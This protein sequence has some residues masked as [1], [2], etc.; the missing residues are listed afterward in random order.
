M[1]DVFAPVADVRIKRRLPNTE[2]PGPRLPTLVQSLLS[3][4]QTMARAQRYV[5]R[6]GD[7]FRIR[8]LVPRQRTDDTRW[9]LVAG[10][11][12]FVSSPE[13]MQEVVDRTGSTFLAG[14]VRRFSEWFLGASS[15]L[16]VDGPEAL[17]ERRQLLS[18]FGSDKLAAQKAE[19]TA[20]AREFFARLRSNERIPAASLLEGAICEVA[21][22][23]IFRDLHPTEM[24][25]LRR[26]FTRSIQSFAWS[27]FGLVFPQ[28][29]RD[30]GKWSP[31]G[32]VQRDRARFMEVIKATRARRRA[33][34]E[35]R[36]DFFDQLLQYEGGDDP[37]SLE[38]LHARVLT[39]LGGLDTVAVALAWCCAHLS[40]HPQM[41][42]SVQDE[43]RG[44]AKTP[45][46]RRS[47]VE[48]ACLEA[49]RIHPAIPIL[50]RVA[51]APVSVGGYSL[52]SGTVVIGAIA[53][54]HRRADAFPEPDRFRPDRFRDLA[55]LPQA[56]MPFGGGARR[57]LGHAI[58]V[59][60]M[61]IVLKELLRRVDLQPDARRI[62]E[63]RRWVMM[64]PRGP[65]PFAVVC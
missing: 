39:L 51:T 35:A 20:I 6:Y 52:R 37:E 46:G 7:M 47:Q 57:C 33:S 28:L 58:A 9:P 53:L 22:R 55:P 8:I 45:P 18:L 34:G 32:R 41:L 11:I 14:D 30:Y 13:L 31:G 61:T 29:A 16:V 23:M 25:E 43:A 17:R 50:V 19:M 63:H 21:L 4:W 42:E 64:A 60:L 12:V 3:G 5:G 49:L 59:P 27:A 10:D 15:L 54:A 24:E 2:I 48:S 40:H 38:R 1:T 56:F 36:N 26:A 65:Q 62:G 44:H